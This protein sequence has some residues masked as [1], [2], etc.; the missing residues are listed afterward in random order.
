MNNDSHVARLAGK[1][2]VVK[3]GSFEKGKR[4]IERN[5]NKRILC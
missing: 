5:A 4:S 1:V 3:N 2:S